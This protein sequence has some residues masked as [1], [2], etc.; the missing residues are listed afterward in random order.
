[1]NSYKMMNQGEMKRK[2]CSFVNNDLQVYKKMR[3]YH[4][5]LKINS[6][7]VF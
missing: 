1:M 4:V 7:I 2:A 3:V 6:S 5:G